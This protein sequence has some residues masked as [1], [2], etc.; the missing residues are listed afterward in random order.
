MLR[1]SGLLAAIWLAWLLAFS[2]IV[3]A[4]QGGEADALSA[5]VIKLYGEGKYAE[6]IPIAEKALAISEKALGPEHPSV[7]TGLNN[8]ALL[9][10]AQGRYSDAEPLSKR[11]LA[12]SEK[13]LGPEHP[14]VAT[15]LNNLAGLYESQGRYSDAEL[16][17]KRALA[18]REKAIGPEHPSVAASLNNLAEL[19]RVQGRYVEAEPLYKRSLAI[20]EKALGPEHPSVATSLNN[21]A[22]LYQAQGRY[23]D[24][25]PLYKRDLA[26]SEKALGPE[27][28]SVATS[29]NN[30]ALLHQA[31]GR[32]SDAEPLYKRALAVREKALGPEHPDVAASLSNL[33]WL[34][35]AQ[36]DWAKAADRWRNAGQLLQRRAARGGATAS[37][38]IGTEKS[39]I[40][41][42]SWYFSGRVKAASRLAAQA[43]KLDETSKS[44]LF[45][46]AQWAQ[47]SEAASS[48]A[49]MAVRGAAGD[50]K[51]AGLVRERQ[52]L[53]AEW[54]VTDKQLIAAK[55]E[56]PDKRNADGEMK[57][58]DRLA[59]I[60]ARLVAID[61]IFNDQFPDYAALTSPKPASIAEIQA[62]LGDNEALVLFL[63]TNDGFKPLPEETFI[64]AVTKTESR[65]VRSDL[66]TK[67]LQEHVVAL[68]CGLDSSAW[69]AGGQVTCAKALGLDPAAKKP[70]PLP[71]DVAKAH[72]LYKGLFGDIEDLLVNADGSGKSLLL[73]PSGALTALPFQVL[74]SK[75]PKDKTFENAAWFARDHA[76]T[77]LPSV[78]GLAALRRNKTSS[79]AAEPFIGFGNP[80]LT[81]S[82]KCGKIIVP[83]TCPESEVQLASAGHSDVARDAG[84]AGAPEDF[85]R[86]GLADVAAVKTRLCPLPDTAHELTCVARSLGALE[87]S[88]VL[89]ADMTET[90]VKATPLDTYRVIHF[91]THGLLAGE[92]SQLAKDNAEPSLVMSP[93]GTP[94]ELDD[95]LLTASE[96]AGLKLNADWVVMSACNTAGAGAPGAEALSGLAKAF[97][98]AGARALLV[99]HWPVNSYA[100]TML[101]S[102][103]F[104]ELKSDPGI[105]RS[106][107]FRRAMLA[108]M[109]DPKRPGDAHPSV[110]APFV[111]VGE[112]GASR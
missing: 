71:F 74:V 46:T 59:A 40:A 27:H 102:R 6:A 14:T 13:A 104:S 49:Q 60:D 67:A 97:F 69:E 112:G 47:S 55:S 34:S 3:M 106:E 77:V 54:Q 42:N 28:P 33:A 73:V 103:T 81:G 57:L 2:P 70:K 10:Q 66:G 31:Q 39:E 45:E 65:W 19:Y 98:Y 95:G 91:A 4:Q 87:S 64:W 58:A 30:L 20:S 76:L 18:L 75:P 79:P 17:Y 15:G 62:Q 38:V 80:V 53:A 86:N 105:G 93:P 94:T 11:S 23:S 32:Y 37:S 84:E 72:A 99:S 12:I 26:I 88:V 82:A 68:R 92:T 111:V 101:T 1:L 25:E 100:A 56:T 89:G 51:L 63:D 78:A 22:L 61:A 109:S 43:R 9:Y 29:L 5:Q 83:D 7:A 108:V 90:K 8:L 41:Q 85:F 44:E 107:A 21:L 16:L 50:A 48:L 35:L 96:V 52:D 24:A 36:N 110:W